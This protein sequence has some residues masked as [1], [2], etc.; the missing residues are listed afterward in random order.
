MTHMLSSK[1]SFQN[2]RYTKDKLLKKKIET[3][4]AIAKTS[5]MVALTVS[6]KKED[7]WQV[8]STDRYNSNIPGSEE[9]IFPDMS[10]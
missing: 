5:R 10:D 4:V 9:K 8:A 1:Y 6:L 7:V 2:L 3:E